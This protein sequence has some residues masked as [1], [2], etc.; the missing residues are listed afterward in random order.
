MSQVESV[1]CQACENEV[2]PVLKKLPGQIDGKGRVGAA[3]IAFGHVCPVDGCGARLDAAIEKAKRE[4]KNSADSEIR[5]AVRSA[6]EPETHRPALRSV[7]LRQPE[8]K[9]DLFAQIQSEHEAAIREESELSARLAE[10]RDRR[11]KLDRIV[12][13]MN[14]MQSVIAA[15]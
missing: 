13:A 5:S 4:Q 3:R 8:P 11:E 2:V 10:V 6:D 9:G 1:I 7:P 15:E 14:G 12:A